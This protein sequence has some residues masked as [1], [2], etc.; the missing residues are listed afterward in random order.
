MKKLFLSPFF[1]IFFTIVCMALYYGLSYVFRLKYGV[2]DIEELGITDTLT[3]LFY[4][5]AFGVVIC[6]YKDFTTIS[7]KRTYGA[8]LFLWF[9][10]LL[11][12]WGLQH[13]LAVNDTTAIKINYFKNAAVPLYAKV[14]AGCVII[15]VCVVI[16]YL[17]FKHLKQ[18]IIGFFKM[19][20][21]YWTIATFGA[22]GVMTQLTDRFPAL[23]RKSTGQMISESIKFPLKIL[24][25]GGE[26]ILPLLFAVAF[27]QYHLC[28][29]TCQSADESTTTVQ[30]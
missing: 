5:M 17:L 29:K 23:Y 27:V 7:E 15:G 14:I 13:W 9:F 16:G 18:M 21:M 2:F 6:L 1:S 19:V 26:S 12:E 8:L 25:E 24:E 3:T 30:D 4:G 10:T 28:K 11:R 22:L 20:P